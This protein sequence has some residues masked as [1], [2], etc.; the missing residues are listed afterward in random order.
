MIVVDTNV[1]AYFYLPGDE[2]TAAEALFRQDSDWV[3]PLLW[4]SG[5][6]NVLATQLRAQ[7]LRLAD[8]QA[9]Q[10]QA[11][12]LLLQKAFAV[13]SAEV[14]RLAAKS[15]CSAYDCEFV[16]LAEY[17]EIPLVTADQRLVRSFPERAQLLRKVTAR[18]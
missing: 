18:P 15:G 16:A 2:T 9:I 11:E 7:R 5:L 8:A 17:L 6:R 1:I 14:L 4:Q 13:D 10:Q 12:Q 3:A